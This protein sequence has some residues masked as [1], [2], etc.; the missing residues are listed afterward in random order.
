MKNITGLVFFWLAA[1][2]VAGL[3]SPS[4]AFVIGLIIMIVV[5]SVIGSEVLS[6]V[7]GERAS[8]GAGFMLAFPGWLLTQFVFGWHLI[9]PANACSSDP[10]SRFSCGFGVAMGAMLLN[11]FIVAVGMAIV[12]LPAWPL[13]RK[14]RD[15]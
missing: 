3:V 13:I 2:F 4:A 12:A 7:L 1:D 15:K 6:L 9:N 8:P 11:A 5:L 14:L 10:S